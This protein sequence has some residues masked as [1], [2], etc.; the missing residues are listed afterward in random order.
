MKFIKPR[1]TAQLAALG[2]LLV[3]AGC[4]DFYDVNVDP[5]N[6]IVA[7]NTQLL[8][9]TQVAMATYL[10]FSLQ[11]LGQATS[12][13]VGQLSSTRG[14]GAFQ[15]TGDSFVNQWAGL[16][17]DMLMNNEQIILQ[18]TTAKDFG[19]K[20][21]AQIQKAYIMSI[22]VDM[23]GDVPYSQALQGVGN[24]APRYDSGADIY[25]GNSSKGIQSL[26]S[27][28][29]EGIA[30]MKAGGTVA[31]ESDIIYRGNVTA[32]AAFG[33]SLKLK[34]YNQIRKTGTFNTQV[35]ALL[36]HPDSLL[37]PGMNFEVNYG[38]S[39]APEN[40]NIGFLSDYVSSTRENTIGRYFYEDFINPTVAA[41]RDPRRRY[42]FYNQL[43]LGVSSGAVDYPV[44]TTSTNFVTVRLGSTGPNKGGTNSDVRTLPGLYPVGGRYDA[45]DGGGAANAGSGSGTAPQR[46]YPYYASK[47][48]EAELYLMVMHDA[49]SAETALRVAI[50]AAF[51]KVNQIALRDKDTQTP[52]IPQIPQAQI[53]AYIQRKLSKVVGT[54][55]VPFASLPSNDQLNIIMTEKYIAGFG[56]GPDLYTDMRR[57]H[58]PTIK[59]PEPTTADL[60]DGFVDDNELETTQTGSWPHVL[61]YR[62]NDLLSNPNAPRQHQAT[63]RVF[64]DVP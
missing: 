55:T 34:L 15:Q 12:T 57:T 18:S 4:K 63:D 5:L 16:Y 46:L 20:G 43:K 22:M 27:L 44:N 8:P 54:A 56:T 36:A 61:Y 45:A 41:N 53:D 13:L 29:D 40:R 50:Q 3:T 10:G 26:F 11:G 64:W 48:T 33:R 1:R 59:L 19:Y 49:A 52:P 30:N 24:R 9:G 31:P 32:W 7:T 51:D 21:I 25:N 17:T 2:L 28:I 39:T 60:A 58:Y 6:P 62:L 42:Y 38:I 47:F 23:W 37:K 14:V 35:G